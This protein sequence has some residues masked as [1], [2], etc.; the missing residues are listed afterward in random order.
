MLGR[1]KILQEARHHP[2]RQTRR[3]TCQSTRQALFQELLIGS[4]LYAVVFGFFN[5][6]TDIL[7]T[8]SY[9]TT[10]LAAVLMMFL[11]FPAFRLKRWIV[12]R[13]REHRI[14]KVL[15]V[16]LVMFSSKFVFLGVIDFV[17]GDYVQISGFAGLILIIACATVLQ[18][19]A[20]FAYRKLGAAKGEL[21]MG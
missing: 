21:E 18:K 7:T 20:G 8:A 6:Y 5:D 14:W 11:T 4:L 15:C 3:E 1:L 19:L 9:T 12:W 17:F 2:P 10:F 13:L 16:W